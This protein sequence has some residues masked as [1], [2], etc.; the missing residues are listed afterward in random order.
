[1]QASPLKVEFV[2]VEFVKYP[3]TMTP[4]ICI[5]IIIRF[6][7]ADIIYDMSVSLIIPFY[8]IRQPALWIIPP[9]SGGQLYTVL[10]ALF[11]MAKAFPLLQLIMTCTSCGAVSTFFKVFGMTRTRNRDS[12][13]ISGC[14]TNEPNLLG[15]IIIKMCYKFKFIRNRVWLYLRVKKLKNLELI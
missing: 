1:M 6:E 9:L 2:K 13:S 7:W 8:L 15:K 4:F 14:A 10:A 3:A 11:F 12:P 5:K